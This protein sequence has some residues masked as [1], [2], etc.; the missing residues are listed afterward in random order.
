MNVSSVMTANPTC[1]TRETPL[2]DVAK[3]MVDCDCG[4]IPVVESKQ[5]KRPIGVVT[6][7]DIVVR[8]VAEGR[9]PCCGTAADCMSSDVKTVEESSSLRDAVCLMEA[10]QIRRL[11]VVDGSGKLVGIVAV[12]DLALAGKAEATAEIVKEVSQP[13]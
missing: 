9:D 3:M 1:C 10:E 8:M 6:D 13:N 5:D 12:A 7:R 11:P 2:T 4:Q